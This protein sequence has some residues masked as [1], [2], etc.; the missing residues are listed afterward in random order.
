MYIN[1]PRNGTLLTVVWDL[2]THVSYYLL[3]HAT[4]LQAITS[5]VYVTTQLRCHVYLIICLHK[6]HVSL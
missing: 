2:L 1:C 4:L 3:L 5:Y 6:Y